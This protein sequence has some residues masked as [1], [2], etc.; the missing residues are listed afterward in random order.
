MTGEIDMDGGTIDGVPPNQLISLAK[1]RSAY[2]PDETVFGG[3]LTLNYGLQ[4]SNSSN[5]EGPFLDKFLANPT[6]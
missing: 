5:I 6:L 2:V 4:V 1:T 3:L